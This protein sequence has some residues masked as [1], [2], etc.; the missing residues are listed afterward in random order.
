MSVARRLGSVK[1]PLSSCT[2]AEGSSGPAVKM[3]RGRWYLKLRATRRTPLASSA[4]ARLSPGWPSY[5]CPSNVKRSTWLRSIW[6][7]EGSRKGW[8]TARRFSRSLRLSREGALDGFRFPFNHA[9]ECACCALGP[10]APLLP[11]LDRIQFE[12]EARCELGL[13][14]SEVVADRR[15]IDLLRNVGNKAVSRTPRVVKRLPCASQNALAR[16]RHLRMLLFDIPQR[17]APILR[18]TRFAQPYSNSPCRLC[19]RLSTG[20]QEQPDRHRM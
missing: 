2:S 10:A 9:K 1:P 19:R 4:E 18:V 16:F 15:D 13:R 14:Q 20:K 11:I 8:V 12:A 5:S 17:D 6:P 3:P 7:P